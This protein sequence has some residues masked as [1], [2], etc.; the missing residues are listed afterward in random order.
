MGES[1]ELDPSVLTTTSTASLAT[2]AQRRQESWQIAL[3]S[4]AHFISHYFII[5]LAPL[6]IFIR[7]DYDVSYTELGFAFVAFNVVTMLLQTPAGFLV[8]RIGGKL[9]VA[10]GGALGSAAVSIAALVAFTVVPM[11]LQAPAAFLVARIGATLLLA[12][13]V[14]LGSAAIAIAG[15]V[16][17]FWVLVAMFGIAGL[18]NTVYHPADYTLLSQGVSPER[19]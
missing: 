14:A 6:F 13:G 17:S 1:P 12:G 8:D 4:A 2:S 11:L 9:L 15:I 19:M 3:V 7:A 5:I 16:D 10:C 18:A